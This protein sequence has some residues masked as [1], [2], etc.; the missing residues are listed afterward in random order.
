[1]T[2]SGILGC[3]VF[4]FAMSAWGADVNKL[5]G[6]DV[7]CSFAPSQSKTVVALSSA[8]GGAAATAA[9]IGSALGL[10]VVTHSSGALILSGSSGY[11]A[12]TIGAAAAGP[13]VVAVGAVVAGTAVSIEL[14]CT[15]KNHP[16]GYKR[17]V[18]TAGEFGRRT[19]SWV[20]DATNGMKSSTSQAGV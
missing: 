14:L 3:I 18:D 8:A 16:E 6:V 13:V 12:G 9:G 17:V 1:M 11:I 19:G 2:R 15:P 20:V 4:A 10:T 5:T 7:V